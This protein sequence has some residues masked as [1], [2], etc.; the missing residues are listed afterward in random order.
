MD[1][2]R[3]KLRA[4]IY[5]EM[6]CCSDEQLDITIKFLGEP[7]R[8]YQDEG[9]CYWGDKEGKKDIKQAHLVC[10]EP[11]PKEEPECDHEYLVFELV[12]KNAT[13]K[14]GSWSCY[15]FDS[16]KPDFCP[17]CGEKLKEDE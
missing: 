11:I 8:V 15:G 17:K 4:N 3:S 14:K 5:R 7:K 6:G 13:R 9:G 1:D 12:E 2:L 16:S 10:I